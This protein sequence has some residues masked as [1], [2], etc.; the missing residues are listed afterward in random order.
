MQVIF[1]SF[2]QRITND[3]A[4]ASTESCASRFLISVGNKSKKRLFSVLQ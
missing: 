3:A 1:Y 4:L 2:A